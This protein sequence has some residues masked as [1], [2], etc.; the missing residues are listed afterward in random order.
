MLGRPATDTLGWTI[1]NAYPYGCKAG[2]Q[3]TFGPTTPSEPAPC[4]SFQYLMGRNRLL[5]WYRMHAGTAASSPA[6]RAEP[7]AGMTGLPRGAHN[8]TTEGFRS[9]VLI[10]ML[11][12]S[13]PDSQAVIA[14]R[15]DPL[16]ACSTA[17]IHEAG[18]CARLAASA[19]M[20]ACGSATATCP[21][22]VMATTT[23][24]TTPIRRSAAFRSMRSRSS[25]SVERF[26][27]GTGF[28]TI[29]ISA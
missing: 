19:I 25:C 15:R 8:L 16:S 11:D 14:R 22:I 7:G 27:H 9:C 13:G 2:R 1:C 28:H 12:A 18:I 29:C 20:S 3:A 4:C 26:P 6:L 21:D 23:G 17:V 24:S 5:V 10:V